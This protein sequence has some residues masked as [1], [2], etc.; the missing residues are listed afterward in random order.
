[1]E[2]RKSLPDRRQPPPDREIVSRRFRDPEEEQ[3]AY[4]VEAE[5]PHG[6]LNDLADDGDAEHEQAEYGSGNEQHA[7]EFAGR[8][9]RPP[10]FGPRYF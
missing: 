5:A 3:D 4:R 9:R 10:R 7:R 8:S 2:R 6:D 1:V